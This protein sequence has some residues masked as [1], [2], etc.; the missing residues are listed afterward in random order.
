MLEIL[1]GLVIATVCVLGWFAG[2]LF[3]CVFLTLALLPLAGFGLI[4]ATLSMTYSGEG[5]LLVL[6]CLALLGVIWAPRLCRWHP[7]GQGRGY[8]G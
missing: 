8:R 4:L 5:A 6:G 7:P 1:I 3:V 2:N